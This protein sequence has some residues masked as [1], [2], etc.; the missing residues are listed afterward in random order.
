MEMPI[1]E[2][3]IIA[4]EFNKHYTSIASKMNENKH[5][6]NSDHTINKNTSYYNFLNNKQ[7]PL[8][9]IFIED[10]TT[11]EIVTIISELDNG[12]ASNIPI[13]IIKK[14]STIISPIL[15][16]LINKNMKT[17]NF[18]SEF[19]LGR[20]SPIFKKGDEELIENYRPVST[21]PIFGKI[22]EKVI[23][24]RLHSFL[25]CK[26]ILNDNQFGYRTNHSTSHALNASVNHIENAIN[27]SKRV[28]VIFIDLSKAFD[29]IDHKIL[30]D[31]LYHYGIR[32]N[33]HKLLSSYLSE[34]IQY[35]HILG[36]DSEKLFIEYGV[37]QGS[38]LGPLLFLIYIND[39]ANCSELVKFILFADD[40]NIFVEHESP[41][42]VYN[43]ANRILK[44]V[45][46]Y[47]H[48]N[49]LHINMKKCCY[50][51]TLHR[52]KVQNYL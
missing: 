23:Y 28:L 49:K 32:G 46:D 16:K 27:N 14:T 45:V 20:I 37:P 18:P 5:Q 4:N 25:T 43:I 29:T 11:E 31:K 52:T 44:S 40:T 3:R 38:V 41:I 1:Y 35:T 48:C 36:M 24:S 7:S 10:C 47:M 22:F 19:K 12:K 33:A 17:G 50:V 51:C 30:L 34:R 42:E 15:M 8:G 13:K 39:I 6:S 2:R 9:S 26:H 21:I